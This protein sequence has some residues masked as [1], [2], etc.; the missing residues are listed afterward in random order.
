MSLIPKLPGA[1]REITEAGVLQQLQEAEATLRESNWWTHRWDVS[2][3][4]EQ[5]K[6]AKQDL[7]LLY[8]EHSAR[9][10]ECVRTVRLEA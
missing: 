10:P 1:G 2:R 8:R 6:Q 7:A 5:I 3:A 9:A 4:L